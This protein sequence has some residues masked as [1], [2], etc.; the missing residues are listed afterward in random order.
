MDSTKSYSLSHEFSRQSHRGEKLLVFGVLLPSAFLPGLFP[1]DLRLTC[2][3]WSDWYLAGEL[4]QGR[5]SYPK[6]KDHL[7]KDHFN[8]VTVI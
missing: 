4:G 7:S 2:K 3:L 8:E 6:L 5:A 1:L